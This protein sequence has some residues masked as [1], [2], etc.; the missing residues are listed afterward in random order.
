IPDPET[1]SAVLDDIA[2]RLDAEVD[3]E[4]ASAIELAL[5]GLFLA[6]RIGKE[7]DET[8]QTIYG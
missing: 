7:A 5:E 2:T 8:G 6:R 1:T 4:R 3:G